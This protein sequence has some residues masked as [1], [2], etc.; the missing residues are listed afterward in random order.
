MN[1]EELNSKINKL[2]SEISNLQNELN[3]ISTSG[4]I[5][6]IKKIS[7][8]L[9]DK[10]E[11]LSLY[12]NLLKVI[13]EIEGVD[14]ILKTEKDK[15]ITDMANE[16]LTSLNL[17]NQKIESKIKGT[18]DNVKSQNE[19]II[20]IRAGTGGQ[21]ANLFAAD[22]FRMYALYSNSK[23]WKIDIVS[24]NETGIGGFKEIIAQIEGEGCF[25]NLKFEN[26]VHRVQRVPVT[27]SAGRI[28]TS[29]A[30][31]VIYPL[32]QEKEINIDPKDLKI[33]VY[34]STGPGGQSVNRTD[35]AVRVSH[36]PS[37]VVVTCQDEKSQ[38][39]NKKKAISILAAKLKDIED[40]KQQDKLTNIRKSAI[41]TGGRSVKIRTY[42]FPQDRITDHRIKMSWHNIKNILNGNIDEILE[43]LKK[44][45]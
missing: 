39:K 36:I 5:S 31:V 38:H 21:E 24:K 13:K 41:Q 20:E 7:K 43:T 14:S 16:E 35:S 27:E 23:N 6:N 32:L 18:N 40:Q 25:T 15:S 22:L 12:K 2:E 26:G 9:R 29:T 1:K 34:R 44:S 19:C 3:K 42:N 17:Q 28:H 4:Q 10:E 8:D 37:G 11:K 33:D 30:S 45:V